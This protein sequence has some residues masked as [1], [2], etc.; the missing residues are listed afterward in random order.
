MLQHV[1][2]LYIRP[3]QEHSGVPIQLD[4][5]SHKKLEQD[6]TKELCRIGLAKFEASNKEGWY[7]EASARYTL[8]TWRVRR[9]RTPSSTKPSTASSASPRC[10]RNTSKKSST[11]GTRPTH[12]PRFTVQWHRSRQTDNWRRRHGK[13]QSTSVMRF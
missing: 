8:R 4:F 11:S 3:V 13:K 5:F 7:R 12:T 2:P 10:P 9:R 6:Q 1:D